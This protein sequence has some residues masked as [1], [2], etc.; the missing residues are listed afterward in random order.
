MIIA[1]EASGDQHGSKLMN[2]INKIST[3]KFVGIGGLQM[4]KAGLSSLFPISKM[5]VMGFTEIIKHLSFFKRVQKTILKVIS[6]QKIDAVILIDYPGFNLRLAK[7]IKFLYN[8]P[9]IY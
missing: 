9:I 6:N 8:I 3:S 2:S 5:S 1:G 7:K 4:T